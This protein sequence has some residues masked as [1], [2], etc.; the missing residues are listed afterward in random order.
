MPLPKAQLLKRAK[1]IKLIA[2]DVDGV[3]TNGDIVLRDSGE[4]VKAWNAKDRLSLALVRD[5]KVP[6]I[7]AWITGRSSKTVEVTAADLG[8]QHLVQK[9]ST[10]KEALE[11]ILK[12]HSLGLE[13][14]AFIGDDIIDLPVMRAVGFSACPGDA[15]RDVLQYSNYISPLLGG[16]GV[17]RDV[18]EYILRAQGKWDALIAPF[19][20]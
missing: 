10:K 19:L 18:L 4:E 17:V 15:V 16:R 20:R 8:I 6:L 7:F 1:K 3:L 13:E 14:A 2:M 9:S 5:S 12:K 11:G